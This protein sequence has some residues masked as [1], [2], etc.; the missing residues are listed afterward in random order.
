MMR[1]K[2]KGIKRNA[3]VDTE[4]HLFSL[5]VIP[6]NIQDCDCADRESAAKISAAK[7]DFR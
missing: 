7:K 1:A 5:E 2:I 4:G 6:A 3:L